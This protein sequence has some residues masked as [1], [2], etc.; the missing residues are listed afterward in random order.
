[1]VIALVAALIGT[2]TIGIASAAATGVIDACVN[3]NSGELKIVVAGATC[4]NNW[5]GLH[6]NAQGLTG[7]T[8]AT[9][10]TGPQ[11]RSGAIGVTGATGSQG[12]TG[13]TGATGAT[14]AT[15]VDGV[16]GQNGADGATGATGA[17]GATGA[18]GA[19]GLQG[20][21]GPAG[22]AQPITPPSPYNTNDTSN[23]TF[24][25]AFAG[26][27]D[28]VSLT[29][30]AGCFDKQLGLEY[31]DCYF[32]TRNLSQP[33]L[34]WLNDTTAQGTNVRRDL[35]VVAINIITNLV[36]SRIDIG[37]GFLSEFR[38]SDFD[39]ASNTF[40]TLS[41]VVVPGSL[42]AG[43]V[44]GSVTTATATTFRSSLFALSIDG[45]ALSGVAGVRGIHVSVAKVPAPPAGARHQFAPGVRQ[46]DGF[47]IDVGTGTAGAASALYLQTWA[48]AV[49]GGLTDL[50]VVDITPLSGTFTSLG[51][52]R[53]TGVIPLSALEPFLV[54]SRRSMTL[55]EARLAWIP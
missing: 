11:G 20:P 39:G 7:A 1:M 46:Y 31:E 3:N 12:L 9:G 45:T 34:D 41:F 16:P 2:T 6:W 19:T 36:V 53:L 18:T 13:L 51:A 50:R 10:A 8:G 17:N 44:G 47:Q 52:F 25:L 21:A 49:A 42:Q 54:G 55:H 22:G 24:R 27:V 15:G 28:T 48:T 14:G 35:S 29:S 40:G 23:V 37:N 26:V 4:P 30:F 38:V 5:T 32:A 33:V 43:P